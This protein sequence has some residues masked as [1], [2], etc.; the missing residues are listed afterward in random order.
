MSSYFASITSS[1]AIS[2]L[3]TR[4]TS[5]RRAI[6]SDETDDPD[7]E[8]SSH[9]SNVL[10]AY[11][12]EKGRVLPPWLPPD[13]KAPA[14][15][16]PAI[17]ATQASRGQGYGDAA[18]LPATGGGRGGL[19]DLWGDDSSQQRPAQQSLSLRRPRG[20]PQQQPAAQQGQGQPLLHVSSAP[21]SRPSTSTG[22]TGRNPSYLDRPQA[23]QTPPP[24]SSGGARPLPSQRAGS[25]QTSQAGRS[26][27]DRTSSSGSAQDRLRARLHGSSSSG[28]GSAGSAPP[29]LTP[30]YS[31]GGG[32]GGYGTSAYG[33]SSGRSPGRN[34]PGG[35]PSGPRPPRR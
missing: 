1:T 10:R 23:S 29:A 21:P 34:E 31:G 15:A 8:D 7:S 16:A 22:T 33:G 30:G 11:Y 35:L 27:L 32:G 9:I 2:N 20:A 17:V 25:Y 18:S 12:A 6:T 24:Q 3:S 19:G 14:A 5:L 28:G 4:F 13:P 26:P